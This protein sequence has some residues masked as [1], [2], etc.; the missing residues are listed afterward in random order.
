ME[1]LK[2]WN[3]VSLVSCIQASSEHPGPD[4]APTGESGDLDILRALNDDLGTY[5][6]PLED[7]ISNIFK[8]RS[9]MQQCLA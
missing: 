1:I 7:Y 3:K 6:T 2:E 9:F 5:F 8:H 4:Y